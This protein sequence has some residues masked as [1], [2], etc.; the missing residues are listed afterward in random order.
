MSSNVSPPTPTSTHP[1]SSGVSNRPP[2]SMA[3]GDYSTSPCGSGRTGVGGPGGAFLSS[4]PGSV[5]FGG[6]SP[7]SFDFYGSGYGKAHGEKV[8]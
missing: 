5:G 1:S 6:E 2:S 8:F 4:S 3:G 7:E